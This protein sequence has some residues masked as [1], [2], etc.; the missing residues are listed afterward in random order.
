MWSGAAVSD[1]FLHVAC[2]Y[3]DG[4]HANTCCL[5]C[6]SFVNAVLPT[7]LEEQLGLHT[8]MYSASA[9]VE[10]TV[11]SSGHVNPRDEPCLCSSTC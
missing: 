7:D 8:R 11:L 9:V 5:L 6:P 2:G 10:V 3:F 1:A 4:N